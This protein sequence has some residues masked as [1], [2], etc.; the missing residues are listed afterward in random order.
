MVRSTVHNCLATEDTKSVIWEQLH[1][2]MY[3]TYS[4]NKWHKRD[5]TCPL[6]LQQV[7]FC[8]P[9]LRR[10]SLWSQITPPPLLRLINPVRVTEQEMAF[11]IL[12]TAPAVTLRNWLTYELRVCILQQETLAYH[13][14]RGSGNELDV[15]RTYNA[16]MW[17]CG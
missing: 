2:K 9:V 10:V 17:H 5:D 15:K 13:N 6:C 4:Y 14:Q 1:L 8:R 16:R 3:I 11:G 12:G 7:T